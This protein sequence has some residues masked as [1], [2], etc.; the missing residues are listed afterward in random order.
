[1]FSPNSQQTL[2]RRGSKLLVEMIIGIIGLL[3]I[4]LAQIGEDSRDYHL[5]KLNAQG[6][7]VSVN[8]SKVTAKIDW[9]DVLF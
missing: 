3:G 8:V 9:L 1:M 6:E 2:T 4:M 5:S 7:Q